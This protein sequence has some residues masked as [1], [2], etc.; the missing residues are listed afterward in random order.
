MQSYG[1]LRAVEGHFWFRQ[2]LESVQKTPENSGI[3]VMRRMP[4]SDLREIKDRH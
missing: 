3:S 1:G 2:S 4:P